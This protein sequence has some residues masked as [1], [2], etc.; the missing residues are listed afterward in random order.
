MTTAARG[1]VGGNR[2]E[3]GRI[4]RILREVQLALLMHLNREILLSKEH[5]PFLRCP[6]DTEISWNCHEWQ[7]SELSMEKYDPTVFGFTSVLPSCLSKIML[8]SAQSSSHLCDL[9]I[10]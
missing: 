2:H 4:G 7:L 5:Q 6:A 9:E 8:H 1:I 10:E 3:F